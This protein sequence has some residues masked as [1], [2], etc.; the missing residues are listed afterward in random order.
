MDFQVWIDKYFSRLMQAWNVALSSHKTPSMQA[1]NEY[2]RRL[3]Q[4]HDFFISEL[5]DNV[6][7][8]VKNYFQY[9]KIVPEGYIRRYLSH[10]KQNHIHNPLAALY[11]ESELGAPVRMFELIRALK[12]QGYDVKGKSILDIGCSNGALLLACHEYGAINLVGIDVDKG[13]LN[14]GR[15]L[16]GEKNITLLNMDILSVDL[17]PQYGAFDIIFATDVIEHISNPCLFFAKI[18][19]LLSSADGTFAFLSLFN[20]YFFQNIK[21]EPH[22]N[23]PGMILLEHPVAKALWYEVRDAM[24]STLEYEVGRWDS[25][26]EYATMA[27]KAGLEL[28][29]FGEDAFK[30]PARE[31]QRTISEFREDVCQRIKALPAG[32]RS[33][34]SL[35]SALEAYCR[36]YEADHGR[37]TMGTCAKSVLYN[38]YYRQPLYML[39]SHK[40][41]AAEK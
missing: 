27:D 14:S 21:S 38:K 4:D 13:R 8:V 3:K 16:I 15:L 37:Y 17:P 32:E 25:F 24:H 23:V 26:E 10:I 9:Y 19:G 20:R 36:M 28:T 7:T 35:V 39:C 1:V 41:G 6:E 30:M 18:K 2:V 40:R 22:Y 31:Y 12:N 5:S 11:I 33:K 29:L 34:Q